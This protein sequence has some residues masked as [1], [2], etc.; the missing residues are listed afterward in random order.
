[1]GDGD[2]V[3]GE[4]QHL[5]P[6]L[7]LATL[8]RRLAREQQPPDER[9]AFS[10][11]PF[12]THHEARIAVI[13]DRVLRFG[14]L[15]GR[16]RRNALSV[17]VVRQCIRIPGLPPALAGMRLLQLSDLH[18][19]MH[20]DFV[21]R[22]AAT[23]APIAA[24]ACVLTGDYCYSTNGSPAAALAALGELRAA[25]PGEVL[26][27]LG[28]HDSIRMVPAMEALD[29]RVLLNESIALTHNGAR[30]HVAGIDDPHYFRTHDLA[31]AARDIP[32]G[33]PKLLLAH[34][35]EIYREA[36]TAGF[37]LVLCGHTHGGQI[38]LPGGIPLV[39]NADCPRRMAAGHWRW[40]SLQGYTS[41]GAGASLLP[42]RFNCPPEVVVHTL[43]VG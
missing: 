41:V 12:D 8:R 24:D 31:A 7:G 35:P 37:G 28:N 26:A 20:P 9:Q 27:V 11:L 16:G 3:T 33:M 13:L 29:I 36:A 19:D 17:R 4:L 22:L 5:A 21:H 39:I 15:A 25:L 18:L 38:R 43:E 34:S 40:G 42:V 23:V 30:L 14:R 2:P 6:R 10:G 32:S 1:M